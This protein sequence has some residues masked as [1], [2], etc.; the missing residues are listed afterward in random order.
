MDDLEFRRRLFAEPQS[1]DADLQ[2]AKQSSASRQKISQEMEALD[3]QIAAALNVDV[4]SD[5]SERLILRQTLASH[6]HNKRKSRI[7]LALAASVALV[8]GL[9]VNTF[10]F[11]SAHN[12]LGDYALAHTYHEVDHFTNN[13][14]ANV[15]LTS[16]NEKMASFGGS[17][18]NTMGELIF[19]DFCRFDGMKSL[20]L[21]FKGEHSPVNVYVVPENEDMRFIANFSDQQFKGQ[22]IKYQGRNVII[23]GDK[24]ESLGQW[25]NTIDSN[26][27]WSI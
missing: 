20:H 6:Q 2:Q 10:M 11:S 3:N 15:S 19:A 27:Q 16:L 24:A 5:L 12:N 17:F 7:H 1:K 4:P 23:V 21:I 13:D 26:I 22:S 18:T 25:Q 14:I 9:S 8:V